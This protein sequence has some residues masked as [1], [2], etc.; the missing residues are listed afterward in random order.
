MAMVLQSKFHSNCARTT[1]PPPSVLPSKLHA[2]R[3]R[4]TQRRTRVK[5][6]KCCAEQ[7]AHRV[8]VAKVPALKTQAPAPTM[9]VRLPK[10]LGRPSVCEVSREALVAANKSLVD[11]HPAY[12]REGLKAFGPELLKSL[13]GVR[14]SAPTG[15]MPTELE[16]TVDTNATAVPSHMLAIYGPTTTLSSSPSSSSSSSAP[17]SP[18]TLTRKVTLY[19]VHSL[20]LAAHCARLPAFPPTTR[21]FTPGEPS[22]HCTVPVRPLCLPSPATYPHLSAFLYTQSP[23]LLLASVMPTP[24][25]TAH[26]PSHHQQHC[27]DGRAQY[28]RSLAQTYTPQR[29]LQHALVLHG[30]WRNGCAL[31]VVLPALWD[32]VELAWG[33]L[34]DAIALG[35]GEGGEPVAVLV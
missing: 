8:R 25:P 16:I 22:V 1:T 4:K 23:E 9:P 17:P 26:L 24:P 20:Y 13:S 21:R 35:A 32:T 3:T 6:T 19:P 11:V 29:L 12:L 27:E 30:V 7:A 33:V 5:G 18:A 31:G 14:A 10:K 28:V 34:L 15:A 2:L